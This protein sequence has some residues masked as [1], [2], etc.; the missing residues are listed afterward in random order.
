MPAVATSFQRHRNQYMDEEKKLAEI[1]SDDSFTRVFQSWLDTMISQL[2]YQYESCERQLSELQQSVSVPAGSYWCSKTIM[3]HCNLILSE[4]RLVKKR[5]NA[6]SSD[7]SR[8]TEGD[9]KPDPN[10]NNPEGEEEQAKL[11]DLVLLASCLQQIKASHFIT[12]KQRVFLEKFEAQLTTVEFEP[13]DLI[14]ILNSLTTKLKDDGATHAV[15]EDLTALQ[16]TM[17]ELLPSA[18]RCEQL[19]EASIANGEMALAEDISTRQLDTYE[20]ILRLTMDQYPI[21]SRHHVDVAA[22]HRKRRWAIFRMADRDITTVLENKHRAIETCGD[23]LSRIREQVRNYTDD[24]V[25]QRKRYELDRAES[26]RFL[27]QTKEKQQGVW[28]RIFGVFEELKSCQGELVGLAQQRKGE[29]QRRLDVEEREAGRRSG[30]EAFLR[31]AEAHSAHLNDTIANATA[32]RDLVAALNAFVL[33]G[34]DSLTGRYDKHQELLNS[35]LSDLQLQHAARFTDYY[36]AASRFIYRKE[37]SLEKLQG[38]IVQNEQHRELLCEVLDPAAKG[39][40]EALVVL[41]ERHRA[42]CVELEGWRARLNAA[43]KAMAPT[44]RAFEL[45]GRAYVHPAAFVREMNLSRWAKM[46]DYREILHISRCPQARLVDES[47]HECAELRRMIAA[48]EETGALTRGGGDRK[49]RGEKGDN[50]DDG[51]GTWRSRARQGPF[52]LPPAAAFLAASHGGKGEGLPSLL[53]AARGS[54]EGHLTPANILPQGGFLPNIPP[55]S[56]GSASVVSSKSDRAL[57]GGPAT[58]KTDPK[59]KLTRGIQGG[60]F[61]ALHSYQSRAPDELNFERGDSIVCT[62]QTLEEG[63]F[64]GICNQRTGIF[65]INYVD[66]EAPQG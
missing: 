63:W 40:A 31:A 43:E 51:G 41:R 62:G 32:A 45:A 10:D 9:S 12:P 1:V 38:E 57:K 49:E 20:Q 25:Q 36:I 19:L 61:K 56:S 50:N 15:F 11:P 14:F 42:L 33:D 53:P 60:V 21:I 13:R 28:N 54:H 37:R 18:A 59:R 22:D 46:T 7:P 6:P 39:F 16:N 2:D 4:K 65:P 55:T 30:H 5:P 64:K 48:M 35:Q 58:H 17:A 3:Q 47:R 44:W 66:L 29:I 8:E 23:H 52:S 24:D 26:D 34:C 27:Q